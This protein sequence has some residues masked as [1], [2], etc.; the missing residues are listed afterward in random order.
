MLRSVLRTLRIHI[1]NSSNINIPKGK[2]SNYN[3]LIQHH[4][5][6]HDVTVFFQ[7][8]GGG[9]AT[10]GISNHIKTKSSFV[11][12]KLQNN[13]TQRRDTKT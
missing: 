7:V 3:L 8:W 10:C 4:Y 11:K 6:Q 1:D 2:G 5:I 9:S 13:T 12:L